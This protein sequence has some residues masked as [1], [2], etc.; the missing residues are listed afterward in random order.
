MRILPIYWPKMG[1]GRPTPSLECRGK[2]HACARASKHAYMCLSSAS[3][4]ENV[5][6][7][8]KHCVARRNM[9]GLYIGNRLRTIS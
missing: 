6:T 5:D 4:I 9:F 3:K 2:R 1:G 7:E 8:T